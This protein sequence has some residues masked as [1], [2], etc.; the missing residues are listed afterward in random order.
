MQKL[1][2]GVIWDI[3]MLLQHIY[4]PQS[5]GQDILFPPV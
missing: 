2:L 5:N 4:V 1:I 3:R